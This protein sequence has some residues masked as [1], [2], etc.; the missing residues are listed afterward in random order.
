M[1][2]FGRINRHRLMCHTDRKHIQRVKG[3][4]RIAVC[5]GIVRKDVQILNLQNRQQWT[6]TWS[7]ILEQ[8][9]HRFRRKN[10]R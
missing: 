6:L 7:E 3:E 1:G 5:A 2:Y 9:A 10:R 8:K 4:H